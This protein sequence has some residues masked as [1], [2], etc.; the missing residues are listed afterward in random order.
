MLSDKIFRVVFREN[1]RIEPAYLA[2]VMKIPQV[3]AQIESATTGTSAT[4]QNITKPSLLALSLPL[5]PL[6]VQRQMIA[7]SA[8]GR[9]EVERERE[10]AE[11]FARYMR[12]ELESL[13]LGTK[14]VSEA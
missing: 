3:R 5:P 11:H 13:I 14:R 2:E 10:A 7:R 12:V 9:T 4:M 1:S 6:P 8:A